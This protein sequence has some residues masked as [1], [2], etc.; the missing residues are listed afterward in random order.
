MIVW[1][2]VDRFHVCH[3]LW[4]T[5]WWLEK[6]WSADVPTS[7]ECSL[8]RKT[9]KQMIRKSIRRPALAMACL[10]AMTVSLSAWAYWPA[11]SVSVTSYYDAN[12]GLVGVEAVG[13]C[14]FSLIGETG[15][16][17]SQQLY[18]CDDINDIP[19]PF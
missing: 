18:S 4:L 2:M 1:V 9:M 13:A 5:R 14:G 15:V 16:R 8:W 17:S 3:V 19:L 10:A 12:G 7:L 6:M 11:E